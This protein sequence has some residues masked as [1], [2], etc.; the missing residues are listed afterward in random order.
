[1]L[2]TLKET[3]NFFK[4]SPKRNNL[5]LCVIE[6]DSPD[7]KKTTLKSMCKKRW[8]ERHEAYEVFRPETPECE[9]SEERS[10]CLRDVH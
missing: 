9:T 4:Y 2:G 1:M 6:K 8:V 10:R 3:C 5:L 7:A